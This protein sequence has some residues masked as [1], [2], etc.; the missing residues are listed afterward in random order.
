M[1]TTMTTTMTTTMSLIEAIFQAVT[2]SKSWGGASV[3]YRDGEFS[4]EPGTARIGVGGVVMSVMS[5]IDFWGVESTDGLM[6]YLTEN[7]AEL[8]A[9]T[10]SI[11]EEYWME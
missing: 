6:E 9:H 8:L 7:A 10:N 2:R 3:V 5:V 1:N 11:I 4:A